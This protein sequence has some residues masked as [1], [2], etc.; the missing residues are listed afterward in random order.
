[1]NALML[2]TSKKNVFMNSIELLFWKEG[3]NKCDTFLR[4]ASSS[5]VDA[6]GLITAKVNK[7]I[8]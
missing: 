5:T 7:Q 4:L 2:A 3:V 6:L 8:S 1:M